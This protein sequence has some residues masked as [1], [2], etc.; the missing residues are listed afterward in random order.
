MQIRK[1]FADWL[2]NV[3]PRR[4]SSGIERRKDQ[5]RSEEDKNTKPSTTV[6]VEI[7]I[8]DEKCQ[9]SKGTETLN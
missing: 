1:S 5:Q 8:A 2:G 7:R 6:D 4:E 9:E 3:D